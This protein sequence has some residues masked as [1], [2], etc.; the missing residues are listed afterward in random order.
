M[1]TLILWDGPNPLRT[2][3]WRHSSSPVLSFSGSDHGG[4]ERGDFDQR[5]GHHATGDSVGTGGP[6]QGPAAG[7]EAE[8]LQQG[9]VECQ[10]RAWGL[11]F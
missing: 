7:A 6:A 9:P 1:S 3:A 11:A 10:L 8:A 5:A 2:C 4:A